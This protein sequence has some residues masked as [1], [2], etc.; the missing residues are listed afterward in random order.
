LSTSTAKGIFIVGTLASLMVLLI[1][2]VQAHEVVPGRTH[3]DQLDAEVVQGQGVWRKY[4]CNDCHTIL[5]IGGYYAPDM[6]RVWSR[7]GG[8]QRPE[9]AARSLAARIK[10]PELFRSGRRV[11]PNQGLSDQEVH[12]VVAFLRWVDGIDTN[13]W[14]PQPIGPAASR[15]SALSGAPSGPA[16]KPP[17][18]PAPKAAKP[19]PSP[20]HAATTPPPPP[21]PPPPPLDPK[22]VARGKAVFKAKACSVCHFLEGVGGASGPGPDLTHVGSRVS[23][24][25][26]LGWLK[27]PRS[28]NPNTMMPTIGMTDQER[29]DLVT[30]L[31][32]Q[33]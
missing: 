26:L 25:D 9:A 27:D 4:L 14:P 5:G 17:P 1:L 10:H 3:Q 8:R 22:V 33:K 28:V 20:T 16:A 11:M 6:T 2:T 21:P 31:M 29:H 32:A 18:P 15:R 13:H 19:K 24:S 30:F 12:Q 23:A 7:Y